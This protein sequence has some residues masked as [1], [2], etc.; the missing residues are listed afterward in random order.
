MFKKTERR[1]IETYNDSHWA[2]FAV[3]RK[4]TCAY[5]TL[6]W[7]NLVTWSKKQGVVARSNFE[8]EY[9]AMSLGKSEKIWLFKILSDLHQNYEVPMKL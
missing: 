7:G 1:C 2:R 9:R 6:M 3:D 8:V 4:S 5:C